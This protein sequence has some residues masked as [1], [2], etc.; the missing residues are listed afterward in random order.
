MWD[1]DSRPRA[2]MRVPNRAIRDRSAGDCCD[3]RATAA[4]RARPV[5][6]RNLGRFELVDDRYDACL[7]GR[8][9]RMIRQAGDYGDMWISPDGPL[10]QLP[11]TTLLGRADERKRFCVA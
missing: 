1:I 10:A 4:L 2:K 8:D 11:G 9:V 6:Q 7:D 3:D 5:V